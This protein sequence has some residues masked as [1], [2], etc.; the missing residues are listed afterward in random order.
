ME[1]TDCHTS[2]NGRDRLSH[3][4][5]WKTLTFTPPSLKDTDL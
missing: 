3:L 1:D 2:F 5:Y 4:L